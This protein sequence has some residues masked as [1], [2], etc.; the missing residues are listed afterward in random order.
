MTPATVPVCPLG[1]PGRYSMTPAQQR[2]YRWM[3]AQYEERAVEAFS[4]RRIAAEAG[5]YTTSAYRLLQALV[6]RGWM[7]RE[8]RRY[9]FDHPVMRFRPCTGTADAGL[10]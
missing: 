3:V 10:L 7:E 6:E 9:R 5:I 1:R 4:V 8:G 2:L